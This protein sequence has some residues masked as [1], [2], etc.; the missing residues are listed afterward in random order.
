MLERTAETG[1]EII[2][3]EVVIKCGWYAVDEKSWQGG[4]FEV[5]SA[6]NP[7]LECST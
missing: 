4:R 7:N 5:E 3:I 6:A 1:A 2:L